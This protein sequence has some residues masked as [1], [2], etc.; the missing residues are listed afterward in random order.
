MNN[1]APRKPT[2]RASKRPTATGG[3]DSLSHFMDSS[4]DRPKTMAELSSSWGDLS[5]MM[6][7]DEH[8]A[9]SKQREPATPQQMLKMFGFAQS[10]C[11]FCWKEVDV[12]QA[13]LQ[14]CMCKQKYFCR[15]CSQTPKVS[16]HQ[17][18]CALERFERK[19][20]TTTTKPPVTTAARTK[21]SGDCLSQSDHARHTSHKD[22]KSRRKKSTDKSE[23]QSPP[24]RRTMATQRSVRALVSPQRTIRS[25]KGEKTTKSKPKKEKQSSL[26]GLHEALTVPAVCATTKLRSSSNGAAVK[27]G[28]Q[29]KSSGSQ[30]P[31]RKPRRRSMTNT[32][33]PAEEEQ[34]D[35]E[36]IVNVIG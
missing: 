28:K 3:K 25:S 9:K 4:D 31:R 5:L 7:L 8:D 10:H 26:S 29:G 6:E 1:Q 18:D 32:T 12:S 13:Q 27:D 17:Q 33:T 30:A 19:Q 16:Q 14:Q 20:G 11:D 36:S 35:Y 34:R 15:G 21:G 23:P 2:R 24:Q 22:S